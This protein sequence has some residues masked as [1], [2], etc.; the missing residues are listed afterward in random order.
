LFQ[1]FIKGDAET[2]TRRHH[3]LAERSGTFLF[4]ALSPAAM[5]G[6][7]MTEIH[8]WENAMAFDVHQLV[9]F[10]KLLLASTSAETPVTA[11]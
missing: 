4:S 1:L 3:E 10:M 11:P 6:Y 7:A 2:L 5:P 9:P 8:I